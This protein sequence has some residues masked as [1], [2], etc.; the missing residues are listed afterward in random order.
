MN[1][2]TWYSHQYS[3]WNRT[4]RLA[5]SPFIA[6]TG[7]NASLTATAMAQQNMNAQADATNG[8]GK[9][10]KSS[11]PL[12]GPSIGSVSNGPAWTLSSEKKVVTDELTP[13][14]VSSW[15]EK[16][17]E[18]SQATTT[19]QAL[20]NLKRPTLRLMPLASVQ[21]DPATNNV[22]D[23]HHHG[24]EFEYD[25]DAPKCGIYVHVLLPKTHPDAP[26]TSSHHSLS[27]LLVFETVVDGGFGNHL[28]LEEGA[29]LEL[30]RFEHSNSQPSATETPPGPLSAEPSTSG[31]LSTSPSTDGGAGRNNRRRFTNFHFRKR[32]QNRSISGPALAVVDAEPAVVQEGKPKD[33]KDEPEEGV[34]VTIRLA[35]LDEQGTELASPNEQTTYLHIVRFGQ[36]STEVAEGGDPAEDTRP[37]VVKVVKREATIGPHTFHLHEI[38]GLTSSSSAHS[39][40]PTAPPPLTTHTHTYPPEETQQPAP[41]AFTADDDDPQS[42]CLLCLSSPREVVLLP[43]RH[44]VACKDCALNMVEFGAGGNITQPTEPATGDDAAAT[45]G[46]PGA[47][48]ATP[49]PVTPIANQRRKRKAKGWFC[50]VCRQPYTSMLRLT[51]SAPPVA[52]S[53]EGEGSGT[54]DEGMPASPDATHAPATTEVRS[55]GLL[56]GSLRPGFLR[57]LSLSRNQPADVENQNAQVR[58]A[59]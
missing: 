48:A 23:Q 7:T 36:K 41:A 19:L 49:A 34:K 6:R 31:E 25:C 55:G 1:I 52:E 42:E 8:T 35:A 59:A 30:G 32:S 57:G 14:I 17:K 33:G 51:T 47:A 24:L 50:P 11:E 40:P 38:F 46:V 9:D 54:E 22:S 15:V 2:S 27:K 16:S 20:V 29:M 43:C 58:A 26:S 18:T 4:R 44:L 39:A 45:P 5:Q 10:K 13:D 3:T 53:K 21:D 28:K 12:F 56:G 37:W